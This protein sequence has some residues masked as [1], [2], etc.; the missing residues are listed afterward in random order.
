M[1]N[2]LFIVLICVCV[3]GFAKT[4]FIDLAEEL[5]SASF[6]GELV[7]IGYDSILVWKNP[8]AGAI[9]G[10]NIYNIHYGYFIDVSNG[11]TVKYRPMDHWHNWNFY[12]ERPEKFTEI[13]KSNGYW[14]RIGDTCLVV[15]N[16]ESRISVFA[17][18]EFDTY[19]FWDPYHNNSWT[20]FIAYDGP[21]ECLKRYETD[22]YKGISDRL[23]ARTNR[24]SGCAFHVVISKKAFWEEVMENKIANSKNK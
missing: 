21:F 6:V 20:S 8:H 2:L 3:E 18:L 4:R 14:P 22:W 17:K 12:K 16:K 9:S 5:D 11:D 1:K 10:D 7:F 24:E 19:T 15:I 13:L 23:A